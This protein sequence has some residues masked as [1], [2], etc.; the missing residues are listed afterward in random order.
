MKEEG[1]THSEGVSYHMQPHYWHTQRTTKGGVV[2]HLLV[3][4]VNEG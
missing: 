4:P 2:T 1:D 3:L